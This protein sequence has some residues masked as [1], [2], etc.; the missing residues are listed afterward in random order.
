MAGR[1]RF[2][3]EPIVEEGWLGKLWD[4]LLRALR[5]RRE[6]AR[7]SAER[8]KRISLEAAIIIK[9]CRVCRKALRSW[10][11]VSCENK[12]AHSVHRHCVELVK[13]K[14]PDCGYRL[15]SIG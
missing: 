6:P 3:A 10:P 9:R 13:G 15:K 14:C 4:R 12:P 11:T 1:V 5:I 2:L 7:P 8:T